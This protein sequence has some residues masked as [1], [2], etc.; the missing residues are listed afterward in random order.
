MKLLTVTRTESV[1]RISLVLNIK[2]S[3]LC[4]HRFPLVWLISLFSMLE[5][6]C[7]GILPSLLFLP[8]SQTK[9]ETLPKHT[10]KNWLDNESDSVFLKLLVLVLFSCWPERVRGSRHQVPHS[11][12][13]YEI[14]EQLHLFVSHRLHRRWSAV[15]RYRWMSQWPAS[16]SPKGPLQQHLR[17]LQL[18]LPQWICWR[19]HQMW[20]HRRVPKR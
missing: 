11:R 19:W 1:T 13:V 20:G 17:Q 6:C 3:F 7:A 8:N 2:S 12:R 10:L 4:P 14:P 5:Y 18:C 16:L 9:L 15:Q